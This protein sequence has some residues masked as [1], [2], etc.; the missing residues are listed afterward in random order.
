MVVFD[1]TRALCVHA[2][3]VCVRTGLP[4]LPTADRQRRRRQLALA[5]RDAMAASTLTSKVVYDAVA[6]LE[7]FYSGGAVR[8][9][10]DG[11]HLAAACGDEVKVRATPSRNSIL[12]NTVLLLI[13][14]LDR[15]LD[16]RDR[17]AV[18]HTCCCR[19]CRHH[20]RHHHKLWHITSPDTRS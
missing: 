17:C 2:H 12:S 4:Q 19:R 6:K 7:P 11:A 20:D 16:A 15:M 5:P 8:V 1:R 9:S 10:R 18:V 3:A 14:F 13:V